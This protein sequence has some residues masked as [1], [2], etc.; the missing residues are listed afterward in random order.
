MKT[1]VFFNVRMSRARGPFLVHIL[2]FSRMSRARASILE[3]H[4]RQNEDVSRGSVV[5]AFD[6]DVSNENPSFSKTV[7]MSHARGPFSTQ[8][9][10]PRTD[11]GRPARETSSH[12]LEKVAFSHETSSKS[13]LKDKWTS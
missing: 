8:I 7:R 6:R 5:W 2:C 3:A 1:L 13:N 12:C 9:S 11:R 10:T 4:I